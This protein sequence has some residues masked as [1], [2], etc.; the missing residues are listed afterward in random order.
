MDSSDGSSGNEELIPLSSVIKNTV[1]SGLSYPVPKDKENVEKNPALAPVHF[2]TTHND[3]PWSAGL[4]DRLGVAEEAK[5]FARMALAKAFTPPL[6]IGLFGDWGSGKSFFMRL[7]YEHIERL[8]SATL[9]VKGAPEAGSSDFHREVVQIRFNAWH[10]AETNL[11]ASLVEHLFTELDRWY[12][13]NHHDDPHALLD[14]LSTARALTLEAAKELVEQRLEQRKASQRLSEAETQ[15]AVARASLKTSADLYVGAVISVFADPKSDSESDPGIEEIKTEFKAAVSELGIAHLAGEVE[16]FQ[17]V[18]SSLQGEATRARLLFDGFK[19][20]LQSGFFIG[21]FAVIVLATP[22]VAAAA[23]KLIP[24]LQGLHEGVFALAFG[25]AGVTGLATKLLKTVRGSLDKLERS[26]RALDIAVEKKLKAE[27]AQVQKAQ[28]NLGKISA[29]VEAAKARVQVTSAKLA[30]ATQD[31]QEGTGAGRLKQFIRE[32]ADGRYAQH[33]GLI[34]TIRKDFEQLASNIAQLAG[35][36]VATGSD[37][38]R[39]KPPSA[40]LAAERA[41]RAEMGRFLWRYRHELEADELLKLRKPL[42]LSS[43]TA[44][45]IS[46]KRIVIYIDDLDRCPPEKVVDVLQAVHLLLTFPIFVVM[47]AVDVRWVSNALLKHYRGMMSG[48]RDS[49]KD[50]ASATDYLEKIFQIPYWMRPMDEPASRLFLSDRLQGITPSSLGLPP[51]ANDSGSTREEAVHRVTRNLSINNREIDLFNQLAPYI[52]G[53]PRRTL[54]FLN[55]YRLIKVSLK[56][57]DLKEFEDNGFIALMAQIALA[58]GHPDTFERSCSLLVEDV[59]WT[60]LRHDLLGKEEGRSLQIRQVAN[61]LDIY[62]KTSQLIE[63]RRMRLLKKYAAIAR[64]Y[65][66]V[67]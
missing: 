61:I 13:A 55:I 29:D 10:Y 14:G 22:F 31:F 67:G 18:S 63:G 5:A 62:F 48:V 47:V 9:P 32:R 38:S 28:A 60:E 53:S 56:S 59:G 65:S 4:D 58:T 54:R 8:T 25:L 40:V 35:N 52:G 44:D 37:G 49:G 41:F 30:Q 17:K 42:S 66:F 23:V 16:S 33:L 24:F 21:L 20:Q 7:V 45:E 51:L 2:V 12:G 27:V 19:Y 3:D 36:A 34:A 64:R 57:I 15:L 39:E 43:R 46:F 26:K 11:W 6:A 50:I 1:L